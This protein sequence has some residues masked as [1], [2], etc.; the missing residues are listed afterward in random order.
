MAIVYKNFRGDLYY[1]HSRK[2]KKGNTTYH[3]SKKDSGSLVDEMP[4]GYEIYESP[5]GKVYLRK[6][7][8]KL[9]HDEEIKII[10]EGMKKYCP[11]KDFKLEIKKDVVSI[12]T[13]ENDLSFIKEILPIRMD[14]DRYKNYETVMRF[15]LV[16]KENRTFSV[17]R[18]CFLGSIDDWIEIDESEDLRRLV[19]EYV[20]HI[21]QESLYDLF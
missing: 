6:P 2:T 10:E 12:Y 8:K 20:R 11:I 9:I 14:L 4:S 21:G 1:L 15:R 16:D 13:V 18:F 19:K 5:N 3:F 17:E 7:L